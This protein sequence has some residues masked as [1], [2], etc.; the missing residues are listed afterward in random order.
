MT[1]KSNR[2]YNPHEVARAYVELVDIHEA[3]AEEQGQ[4]LLVD[5]RLEL[6][7]EELSGRLVQQL[8]VVRLQLLLQQLG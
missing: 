1:K 6:C 4:E 8:I 2:K 7:D 3:L 5:N